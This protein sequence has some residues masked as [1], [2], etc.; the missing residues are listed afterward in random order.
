[1]GKLLLILVVLGLFFPSTIFADDWDNTDRFLFSLLLAFSCADYLQTNYIIDDP[2]RRES[3]PLM[4]DRRSAMMFYP[5]YVFGTY[6]VSKNLKSKWRKSLLIFLTSC[7]IST[8]MRN[9]SLG[10]GFSF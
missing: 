5:L 6:Q 4:Q 3:N 2:N 9:A 8:T 1:M 7:V 10:V